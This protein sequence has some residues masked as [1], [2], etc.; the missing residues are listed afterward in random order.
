MLSCANRHSLETN[1]NCFV[2]ASTLSFPTLLKQVINPKSE[3]NF[4]RELSAQGTILDRKTS[5]QRCRNDRVTSARRSLSF[6]QETRE[7]E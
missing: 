1:R 2:L 3:N 6:F 4:S 5:L 7:I